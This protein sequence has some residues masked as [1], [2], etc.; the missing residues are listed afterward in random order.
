MAQFAFG[1]TK[2]KGQDGENHI[3]GPS[4]FVLVTRYHE[5][6]KIEEAGMGEKCS[7]ILKVRNALKILSRKP[8]GNRPLGRSRFKCDDNNKKIKLKY[9]RLN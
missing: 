2:H 4:E 7:S 9:T 1:G 3:Y 5:G 6:D 8:E